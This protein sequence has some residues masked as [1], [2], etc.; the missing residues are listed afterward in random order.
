MVVRKLNLEVG[1]ILSPSQATLIRAQDPPQNII[2]IDSVSLGLP[3]GEG[4]GVYQDG[5]KD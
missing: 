5:A 3:G 4:F 2:E 1:P